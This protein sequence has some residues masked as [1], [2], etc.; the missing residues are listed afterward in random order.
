MAT[1]DLFEGYAIVYDNV[2]IGKAG[3]GDIMAIS[4]DEH[5]YRVMISQEFHIGLM[6]ECFMCHGASPFDEN[7]PPR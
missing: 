5:S 7:G 1:E 3:R 4:R 2:I 6:N